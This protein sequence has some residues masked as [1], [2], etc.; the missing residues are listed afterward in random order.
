MSDEV[1]R[2]RRASGVMA[3]R[4]LDSAERHFATCGYAATSVSEIAAEVGVRGPA[5]YKHFQS[6]EVL[7]EA[8]IDRLLAPIRDLV[9]Q[10][11]LAVQPA[12]IVGPL[13]RHNVANP[14]LAR[15]L[16]HASLA[17]GT[18]MQLL[19]QRRWRPVVHQAL[20]LV[21]RGEPG[22]ASFSAASS[23]AS[24][25]ALMAF[26]DLILGYVAMSP[27]HAVVLDA[28]PTSPESVNAQ[29]ELLEHLSG[30]APRLDKADP[31]S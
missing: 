31:V 20:R 30:T 27:L 19:V 3:A 23:V 6:K 2:G 10:A 5:I 28:D 9:T 7:Y 25:A 14:N 21:G 8:V 1:R 24:T 29:V 4:I 17:G 18:E 16:M 22:R 15:L 12:E 11:E 26:N 13:L